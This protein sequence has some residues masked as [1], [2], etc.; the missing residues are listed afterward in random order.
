[1]LTMSL[2]LLFIV[3][4][5]ASL[6]SAGDLPHVV[7]LLV[8]D[9]GWADASW[10]RPSGYAEVQ[11]PNMDALVKA[12]IDLDR[13]YVFKVCSPTR[14][15]IQSGRNPIHVNAQNVDMERWDP[16]NPL[17]GVSGIPV[18]MTC[19]ASRLAEAGYNHRTYAGKADFG[20]AYARQTPKGRGYTDTLHYFQHMN[21]YWSLNVGNC[22]TKAA[23]I[24]TRDLWGTNADGTEGPQYQYLNRKACW[25][26]N[27]SGAEDPVAPFPNAT[28][29]VYEED[30]FTNWT[31][32][33]ILAHDTD[34]DGPMLAFHAPH[35]VHTPL[36]VP[37]D[38]FDRFDFIP[39][40]D[41]RAYHAMSWN[42]D[43]AVGKIVDALKSKGMWNSTLLLM[44]ADNG[45]PVYMQGRGGGNNYPLRYDRNKNVDVRLAFEY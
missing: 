1:M 6:V 38:A 16:K 12:G 22:G 27:M 26:Q 44:S 36:E 25:V 34:H 41:R 13:N 21:D 39:W 8:D 43:R 33:H 20:M 28:N 14:S 31:V 5:L 9:F 40:H 11:T 17:N 29:C 3:L 10:H 42:V 32:E 15:A 24:W 37:K 19:F 18:N 35:S 30:I 23:P 7:M 45:G 4:V 2:K